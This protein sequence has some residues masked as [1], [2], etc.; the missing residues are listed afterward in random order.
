VI[1]ELIAWKV[2][3]FCEILDTRLVKG[4]NDNRAERVFLKI[5]PIA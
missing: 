2:S 1:N 4:G 3:V 5:H